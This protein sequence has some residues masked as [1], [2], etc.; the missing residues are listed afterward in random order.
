MAEYF[1][2]LPFYEPK[3]KRLK[4]INLLSKLPFYEESNVIKQ[5]FRLQGMQRVTKLN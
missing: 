2:T 5:I 1:K 3:I 4:S